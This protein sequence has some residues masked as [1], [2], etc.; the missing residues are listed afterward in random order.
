MGRY[1]RNNR[2]EEKHHELI[3]ARQQHEKSYREG[4]H[5]EKERSRLLEDVVAL[6][7]EFS[8]SKAEAWRGEDGLYFLAGLAKTEGTEAMQEGVALALDHL[9]NGPSDGTP[10]PWRKEAAGEE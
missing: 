8:A 9:Q 6:R 5:A 10:P 4:Y 7:R 3:H 2:I 1:R